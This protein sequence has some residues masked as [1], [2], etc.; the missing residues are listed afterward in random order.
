MWYWRLIG[1][2]N[3]VSTVLAT[4]EIMIMIFFAQVDEVRFGHTR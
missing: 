1:L 2:T 3:L 4:V